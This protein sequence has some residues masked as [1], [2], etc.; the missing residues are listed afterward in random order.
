M[1]IF[2]CVY[3]YMFIHIYFLYFNISVILFLHFIFQR[4]SFNGQCI[5][6]FFLFPFTVMYSI[7]KKLNNYAMLHSHLRIPTF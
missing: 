2:K 5:C 1:Y 7:D 3:M 4:I 6:L